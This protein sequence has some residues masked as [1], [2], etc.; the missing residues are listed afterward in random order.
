MLVASASS[1][2]QNYLLSFSATGSSS[3][4]SKVTV[5]NLRAGTSLLLNGDDILRLNVIT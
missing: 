3:S 1:S 4:V 2:S 5:E